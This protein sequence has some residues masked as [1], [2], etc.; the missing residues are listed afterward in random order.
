MQP[1]SLPEYAA[2]KAQTGPPSGASDPLAK[3]T[4]GESLGAELL[5]RAE[6]SQAALEVAWDELMARWGIRGQ[7]VGIRRLRE[8]FASESAGEGTDKTLSAELIALR[9]ESRR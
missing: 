7:P 1:Q 6:Q 8:M 9:E 4:C 5:R 2:H 3:M